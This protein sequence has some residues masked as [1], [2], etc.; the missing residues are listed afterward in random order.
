MVFKTTVNFN[1]GATS[2]NINGPLPSEVELLARTVSEQ[3]ANYDMRTYQ[4]TSKKLRRW[5]LT[6]TDLLI[7]QKDDLI[8]F[9]TDSVVGPSNTFTYTHTDGTIYT[10]VRLVNDSLQLRRTEPG[11]FTVSMILEFD[12]Q[13]VK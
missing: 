10:A 6:F 8:N 2:I 3:S 1:D 12:A 11:I 7:A 4:L 13:L 5:A 9:F